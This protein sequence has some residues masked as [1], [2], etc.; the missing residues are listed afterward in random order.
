MDW[1]S[2]V[3]VPLESISLSANLESSYCLSSGILP[4]FLFLSICPLALSHSQTNIRNN[5]YLFRKI[6]SGYS[7]YFSY[8]VLCLPSGQ[9]MVE[10][11]HDTA[12]SRHFSLEACC[13]HSRACKSMITKEMLN[14][15]FNNESHNKF[16]ICKSNYT[17]SR[18][19]LKRI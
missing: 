17:Y 2:Y 15:S 6:Y 7:N 8:R 9:S 4:S 10:S 3:V 13:I 1:N 18:V 14:K 16:L 11:V 12:L 19:C 5:L